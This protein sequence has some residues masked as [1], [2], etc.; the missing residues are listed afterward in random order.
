LKVVCRPRDPLAALCTYRLKPLA[1]AWQ[2]SNIYLRAL[3]V[4]EEW[5]GERGGA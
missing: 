1:L 2:Y 4:T 5:S 3:V